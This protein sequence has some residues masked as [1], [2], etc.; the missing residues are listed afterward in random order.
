MNRFQPSPL[1]P[2][3]RPLRRTFAVLACCGLAAAPL[4]AA[5]WR[6]IGPGGG[7]INAAPLTAP[8][9][10]KVAYVIGQNQTGFF[11]TGDGGKTWRHVEVLSA[12]HPYDLLAIDPRNARSLFGLGVIDDRA[13]LIASRDGGAHWHASSAGLPVDGNGHVDLGGGI[14]FD[15]ASSNHVFAATGQGLYESR[16]GGARW[17]LAG[18]SDSYVL[19][20]AAAPP[21]EL[22]AALAVPT[23]GDDD[24]AYEIRRS[25]DG[26]ATWVSAD[27]PRGSGLDLVHFRF[28]PRAPGRPYLL[29]Y[30]GRLL[31]RTATGWEQLSPADRTS[32]I[33]V[34]A[35]GSLVAA[36]DRGAR[37]SRDGG[38]TWTGG[39]RPPLSRLVPVGPQEILATGEYGM[40]RSDDG[41]VRFAAS[42]RG[43]DAQV[44]NTLAVAADGTL[45]AG[46][47]G[48]GLMRTE[49]GGDWTRQLRGLGIDPKAYPPIPSEFAAS[50]SRPEELYA[51]LGSDR[52]Y[53]LARSRDGGEHWSYAT[54]PD[55]AARQ[56]NVR[57]AVD[58]RDPDRI[59]WASTAAF[60]SLISYVWR[61]DDG[62]QSWSAPFTFREHEF[63]LDFVLDPVDP[64]TAFALSTDGLWKST[65]GGK[66]FRHVGR[67]L[68]LQ[69]T[70]GF[71]LAIDPESHRDVY[72]AAAFG[73]YRSRDGGESFTRLGPALP[74]AGQ[75][76]I[77]IASG[78]RVLIGSIERGVE[79]WHPENH[80]FEIVGPGLPLDVFTSRILVDPQDRRT[81]YAQAYGRSVW[82][83]DLDE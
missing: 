75:R 9:D 36:T 65:N 72:V 4:G 39:G 43:L 64:E 15:P 42:S 46:M 38:R 7:Y 14:A 59:L 48:P 70:N 80:R 31:H 34:L 62:G 44:I 37:K 57:L 17:T 18:F 32:D 83:L 71:T 45:W 12:P 5:T 73:I 52:G 56:S 16:D 77:A 1:A 13:R 78:G 24:T 82:R 20:I 25:L 26:G 22:W 58:A 55:S 3:V 11:R 30:Y 60:G 21:A 61:S 51:V 41:G 33:A 53:D 28:D 76:G 66:S 49:D 35:D 69:M 67:G 27:W 23:G 10:A 74:P 54:V 63:I 50:P 19:T 6:S 2:I 47:Q 29:D 68:P 40:W 81:V 8:S 79:L